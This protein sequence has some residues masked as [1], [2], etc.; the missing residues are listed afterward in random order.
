MQETE[1]TSQAYMVYT[2]RQWIAKDKLKICQQLLGHT[3][4]IFILPGETMKNLGSVSHNKNNNIKADIKKQQF[5][6]VIKGR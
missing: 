4:L 5:E 6:I 1:C 2:L 3:N